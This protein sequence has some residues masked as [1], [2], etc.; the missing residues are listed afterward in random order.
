MRVTDELF[1][2]AAVPADV[3]EI[4]ALVERCYR[5]DESR[6]GWTTEADLLDG[7]RTDPQELTELIADEDSRL[8][9][10]LREGRIVA[11][12]AVTREEGGGAYVGMVAVSPELQAAG[13][14]RRRCRRPSSS[15]GRCSGRATHA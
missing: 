13:L 8:L 3:P 6:K 1:F 11:T 5:G 4:F 12:V 9:L 10:G 7:Q 14:G 15:P 2:R